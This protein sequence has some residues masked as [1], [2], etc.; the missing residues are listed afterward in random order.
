MPALITAIGA[1]NFFSGMGS[2]AFVALLMALTNARYSATQFALF[3][4]LD[5]IGRV[6]IGPLAGV[7]ANDYGCSRYWALSLGFGLL[8][9]WPL[10][11]GQGEL[12]A[13]RGAHRPRN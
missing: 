13:A 4:A 5:S 11:R 2:A 7:V 8:G 12:P 1:E 3:T 10:G 6:F 9:L